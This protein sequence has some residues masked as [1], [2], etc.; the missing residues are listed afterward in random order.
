MCYSHCGLV[1]QV[2]EQ[3]AFSLKVMDGSNPTWATEV[4]TAQDLQCNTATV[5]KNS[6][7]YKDFQHLFELFVSE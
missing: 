4:L 1:A 2:A 6:I 5:L 7:E 3:W